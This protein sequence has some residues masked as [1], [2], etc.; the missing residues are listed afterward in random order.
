MIN[1]FRGYVKTKDKSPCQKFGNGEPLLSYEDVKDLP[2]YAG[3]L[4][5]EFTVKDVDDGDEADR[6]YAIVCDLNLNCRIYKTTRGLHFMF[7]ASEYCTKGVVKVTDALG[8][9]FDVRTGKNMYVVLKSKGVVRQIIR[10]FDESRP[11]DTFPKFLSPV[12]NAAKFTGMGD[13]D[14]R[15]G[16]LFKHS[17]L[18]LKS[19]YTPS[20]VKQI[21]YYINTYA[22]AEPLPEEE[23]QKI[24]RKDALENFT[25]ERS[26]A[27]DDFGN[28]LKPKSQNDVGMAELFVKEY[29]G[30]IRYSPS[31]GWLVWNGKQWEMSELKAEQK[32]MEFIKRVFDVAKQEV[33]DTYATYGDSAMESG[34]K[35]A[36][37][38]NEE[39]IKKALAYFKYIN[40]MCDSS[41]IRAVMSVAK[42]YLEVSI[43]ELDANP[44]DLNTPLGIVDLKTGVV[45]PHRAE[46]FCTKMTKVSATDD[47][48]AMWDECL[49]LVSQKDN[50]FKEYLKCVAG[51]IAIGKVYH[52]ALI[53]AFG[54]G[55][56]G[57]STVFNTIYEVLGDYAGKI[58]AESLT[59]RAKNTKV[60]LAELLGKRFVLASETEEG[61]RL[62]TSMLKQIAS[63]D[64]ITAEKKYHDPFTFTPTHTT[65]LYT[66]HLP[67]VGSN[68]KGTWRRLVVAPF[69]ANIKNPRSD[70]GEELIEKA[71][72][73]VLKWIIE[74][75]MLFI[76]NN[77]RLP[78]CDKVKEAVGKY[79]EENDWL[80]TFLEEC[81]VVGELESCAGGVLYKVYRAWA[82]DCGEYMRR[83]RDFADAL[84]VAGFTVQKGK[85]GMTW[86]GLSLSPNR[87]VG[88]TPEED[89]LK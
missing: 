48:M 54:D 78:E 23:M 70:Y 52:E 1:P 72:G 26:T 55:A 47:G 11:I 85:T 56:N 77:Y 30:E 37:D 21:L 87:Q 38:E 65:V 33:H 18:L 9:T 24:T 43:N 57:K 17:A 88:T 61:Q 25:P 51:A 42:S 39:Q 4:N 5:G 36:K 81:C 49:D 64:S 6:V 10:D 14:G 83:N 62:S 53:I 69:G 12:K 31:T 68:D 86:K 79:R 2:E 46:A 22:F 28:P 63:V 76:K 20:E 7:R 32:Y 82:A 19:G 41:K 89:F 44:F 84:R 60:D 35:K 16:A 50:N 8:F 66:N 59:T 15:N 3:I 67:R 34:D 29:K 75:A 45:Y 40:K 74:G 58:P 71:S 73:A 80:A 13:G 27:V